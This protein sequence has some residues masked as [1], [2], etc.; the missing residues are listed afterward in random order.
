MAREVD[1][2]QTRPTCNSPSEAKPQLFNKIVIELGKQLMI[3]QS[4]ELL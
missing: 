2:L 4:A 3:M 1:E